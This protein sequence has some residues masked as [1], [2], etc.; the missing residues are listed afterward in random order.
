ML[1][2]QEEVLVEL[3]AGGDDVYDWVK[4]FEHIFVPSSDTSLQI[5][6]KDMLKLCPELVPVLSTTKTIADPYVIA[7]AKIHSG[8]LVHGEKKQSATAIPTICKKLGVANIT[9]LQFIQSQGWKY[10]R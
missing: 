9:F 8:T 3:E 6:L 7:L 5:S 10:D 2:S 1:I 4:Q